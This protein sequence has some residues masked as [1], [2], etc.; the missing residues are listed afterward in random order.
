MSKTPYSE[1]F[2]AGIRHQR[3]YILDFIQIHQDQNVLITVE[4]IAEEI[5]TQHKID[6][7]AKLQEMG[8]S[9]GQKR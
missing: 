8:L 7:N 4:D 2:E 5:N 6:M 1:G 3:E 9:W